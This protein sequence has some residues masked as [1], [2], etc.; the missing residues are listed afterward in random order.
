MFKQQRV[1]ARSSARP[2]M[3]PPMDLS[4][5]WKCLVVF[6]LSMF[7]LAAYANASLKLA[8]PFTDGA[9]MQREMDA[10]VWG[11][12]KPGVKVTVEFA[13]QKKTA[14]TGK[15]G[16]WM[17]ELDP[18][19][20]SFEPQV[21][22]VTDSA[23][24][25]VT[26]RDILVGEVWLA[27][28]QSNM[29]WIAGKSDV[30]RML[31]KQMRERVEA[32]K[33]KPTVIREGKVTDYYAAPQPITHA[34]IEWSKDISGFS[35]IS[36]AFAYEI[37]RELDVPVGIANSA[38]STTQIQTWIPREGFKDAPDEYTQAIYAKTLEMI[39]GSP[40]N[41]KAWEA[42]YQT[43]E[44]TLENNK[45][46]VAKG[47]PA[48]E[49]S[50][51]TPGAMSGNRDA[52]WMYN[53]RIHPWVPYAIRGAIWNQGYA[54]QHEGIKYRNNL[55]SLVRGWRAVFDRPDLPVYF[56]QFYRPGN[57]PYENA[58]TMSG[59]SE[60]RLGTMLAAADIE[61]ADF[62][63][64]IDIGG[65]IHYGSKSLPG[66]RLALHA[67]K[68]QYGKDIVSHGPIFE[69]YQVKGDQV[70]VN[71]DHAEGGLVVAKPDVKNMAIAE[72]IPNGEDQVTL[73]YLA[74]DDRVW[75][76]AKV[77]ID[78]D[79]V[80]VTSDA[81]KKPRGVSYATPGVAFQPNLYNK[82][83]LPMSPFMYY[84]NEMVL[85]DTWP[86]KG[87]VVFGVEP[88]VQDIVYEY[89][90]MPLLSTQ[91]RDNAVLQ[92]GVPVTIWG[93]AVH[94]WVHHGAE[95]MRA[96][97][98]VKIDFS[99]GDIQKT[100][101]VTPEMDE[102][103]VTLPPMEATT[104]PRTLHV[105]YS[106]D[107]KLVHERQAK[108]VVFGDVWYVAAPV[109]DVE[110][111][112]TEVSD[113]PVRMM[114]NGSKRT[115]NSSPSRFS[116]AVSTT[117]KN[118]FAATWQPATGLPAAIGNRIAAKTGKPV[119]IIFMDTEAGRGPAGPALKEWIGPMHLKD[120]PSL[121][122]DYKQLASLRPGTEYY[123]QNAQRYIEAWKAYWN[124]YV[125][126]IM[127][128]GQVPDK[129]AWGSYPQLAGE[130]TTDASHT[131]N[132]MV[133][134]FTPLAVKGMIFLTGPGAVEADQGALF[135]EQMS[136]LANGWKADFD[137]E[138]AT[139]F[140]TIPSKKLA[141]KITVPMNIEGQAVGVEIEQWPIAKNPR[142]KKHTTDKQMQ[143]VIQTIVDQAYNQGA[144]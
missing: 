84:D 1:V 20:A 87:L 72:V 18:L 95:K 130:V 32:G 85:S 21:M 121:K 110:V 78:G 53:A 134:S 40:Q 99:F 120:A 22:T 36:Y 59:T 41:E 46:L 144:R 138:N 101:D 83:M 81:V 25:K 10:P 8:A 70:I 52:T 16:M 74:G 27:S 125:P 23:G 4:R 112:Y 12:N 71:F 90:K 15:D 113:V 107:G 35:A 122:E 108:N 39:P 2:V 54:S 109:N 142:D 123:D 31:Q 50:T 102:W 42:F 136:A 37:A 24:G 98:D 97:G 124:Q 34:T 135:G 62:A 91:F 92:A 104:K 115:S 44:Q 86:D 140:Y 3:V 67:L 129:K 68:N 65:S 88:F 60:M 93:S 33:E 66:K 69:S 128:T 6:T 137:S 100:I 79:K 76:P 94:P 30:G 118:R 19:K 45:K 105:K 38:F 82:A 17:L 80:V 139:F 106:I 5:V 119:G 103:Q 96:T 114:R 126:E 7:M 117:P 64:Q 49:I 75:H 58:P 63:S 57:G 13:G 9:V 89:R 77:K 43:I 51:G 141:P 11:W 143:T 111:P 28:G 56:H 61:N 73:F 55:N 131:W 116:V 29:Q 14:T 47:K 127:E 133:C 132:V 26:V 48:E